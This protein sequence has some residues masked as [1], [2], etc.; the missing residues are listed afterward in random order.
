MLPEDDAAGYCY[1]LPLRTRAS[2]SFL[3]SVTEAAGCDKLIGSIVLCRGFFEG[4]I[5]AAE[6][7]EIVILD[8]KLAELPLPFEVAGATFSLFATAAAVDDLVFR[9][10]APAPFPCEVEIVEGGGCIAVLLAMPAG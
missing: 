10:A 8:E 4:V 1:C 7:L 9:D 3:D 6:G 5:I 2:R